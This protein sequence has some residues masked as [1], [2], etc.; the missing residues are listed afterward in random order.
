MGLKDQLG[1]HIGGVEHQLLDENLELKT[2]PVP[3]PTAHEMEHSYV[4]PGR[5]AQLNMCVTYSAHWKNEADGMARHA[6]QQVRALAM[7]GM[8][9]RLQSMDRRVILND[10]LDPSVQRL[11]Y[12]ESISSTYTAISIKHFIFDSPAVLRET[13]C[14]VGIRNSISEEAVA[15]IARSTIVYTSWERNVVHNDFV[16]QLNDLGQIWVPCHA[17]RDAFV[18]SGVSPDRVRVVPFP[19]DPEEHTIAA[20]RGSDVVPDGK[21]FYHIGKW[22]PR[23]NQHRLIGA[24]L[25]AFTPKDKA[26]LFIKTS[27]FGLPWANY[28]NGI[29]SLNFWLED[30]R[31]KA[32]GWDEKSMD[33]LIRIV[34]EKL[35]KQEIE[36]IHASNNIYVSSGLGEAWD[37]P[38][39]DAKLAGN[40]LVYVGYGGPA[41][42]ADSEDVKVYWENMEE[43]HSGYLWESNA[44]WASVS[45]EALAE[46]LKKATPVEE[47]V[48]P[49][50]CWRFGLYTIA[51]IMEHHI[52]QLAREL[53]CWR[54]IMGGG[55]G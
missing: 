16:K 3:T 5:K 51:S 41:E 50:L 31:V 30:P 15:R 37:I 29:E 49:P 24:F 36:K 26:S 8:A 25:L 39:F 14:P 53:G 42:Y 10:E 55:F 2:G 18:Q 20:P 17:N 12:L 19:F 47:R 45:T 4:A 6:R 40:R 52:E 7:T 38:A 46:A 35:S 23:K 9:L 11:L 22:E 43:V 44:E 27:G 1:A 21:R 48:M 54:R 32:N 33:R 28:P 34:D 13:I